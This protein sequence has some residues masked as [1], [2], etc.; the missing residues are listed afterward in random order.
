MCK[1]KRNDGN[2][3]ENKEMNTM[4]WNGFFRGA[5]GKANGDV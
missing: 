2:N 4:E 5:S 1:K 3:K